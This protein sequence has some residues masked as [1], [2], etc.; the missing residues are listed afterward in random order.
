MPPQCREIVGCDVLCTQKELGLLGS[1]RRLWLLL[2]RASVLSVPCCCNR[3]PV[4]WRHLES[5]KSMCERLNRSSVIASQSDIYHRSRNNTTTAARG[6]RCMLFVVRS[7]FSSGKH[8]GDLNMG[9]D[10][11]FWISTCVVI[12]LMRTGSVADTFTGSVYSS[13]GRLT[14]KRWEVV[15]V[16]VWFYK[17]KDSELTSMTPHTD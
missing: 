17:A 14:L 7:K 5:I 16:D 13:S 9:R 8:C 4:S 3:L 11:L 15:G 2:C 12:F 1:W 10:K 6:Q